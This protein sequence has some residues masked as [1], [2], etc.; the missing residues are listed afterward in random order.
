L[1]PEISNFKLPDFLEGGQYTLQDIRIKHK[2]EDK[3][4]EAARITKFQY[5]LMETHCGSYWHVADMCAIQKG[6]KL[7]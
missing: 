2:W 1:N 7:D 6:K 3:E 5:C 4:N